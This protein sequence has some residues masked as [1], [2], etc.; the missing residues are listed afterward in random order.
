MPKTTEVRTAVRAKSVREV[1]IDLDKVLVRMRNVVSQLPVE[2]PLL[3]SACDQ[4]RI[5][6]L[7][8]RHQLEVIH[9]YLYAHENRKMQA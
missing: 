3:H 2:D 7:G 5:H 9:D 6:A 8:L 1:V 4:V